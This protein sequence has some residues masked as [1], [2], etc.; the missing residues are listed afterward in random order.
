[1]RALVIGASGQDGRLLSH[2][3][4]QRGV[5]VIASTSAL[6]S[7]TREADDG[8]WQY[9]DLRDSAT[10]DRALA[11]VQPDQIYNLGALASSRHLFADPVATVDIN[12]MGPL[13][14]LEAVRRQCPGARVCQALSSEVFAGTTVSPQV[15]TTPLAPLNPYGA[16]KVFAWNCLQ[17][18]RREFG[19]FVSGL[20]LYNHES[21]RRPEH[22]LPGKISR[23]VA[24]IAA[25]QRS[26]LSLGSADHRRDWGHARDHVAAM[27]LALQATAPQD[28]VIGTGT[29]HS[30]RDF[31]QLAFAAAGLDYRDH[32]VFADQADMAVGRRI[33]Q[34]ELRPDT[35]RAQTVLGWNAQTS[36]AELVHALVDAER[37]ALA[38][39]AGK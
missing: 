22:S 27:W 28:F 34:V 35:S 14:L 17:A 8:S 1:M 10:I 38:D 21:P 2:D 29:T 25:G 5:D 30:V 4:R 15:E 31:C 7:A 20:V 26:V 37:A 33:E 24:Q 9:L 18:Y 36:F 11:E 13:R 32:V 19:L 3:L 12:G 39:G 6:G 16:A 23:A